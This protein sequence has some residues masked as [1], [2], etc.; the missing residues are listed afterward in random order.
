MD[1]VFSRDL[2]LNCC[3]SSAHPIIMFAAMKGCNLLERL[4]VCRCR[5][6]S[7][8]FNMPVA[9]SSWKVHWQ[10]RTSSWFKGTPSV[11]YHPLRGLISKAE[12]V[13]RRDY[14]LFV[15]VEHDKEENRN[16][17]LSES[18]SFFSEK[19]FSPVRSMYLSN[20]SAEWVLKFKREGQTEKGGQ[21]QGRGGDRLCEEKG[22]KRE[23]KE[24]GG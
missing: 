8:T 12:G 17:R 3:R 20:S 21:R 24:G 5:F 7:H 2:R 13:F 23:K 10:F 11:C 18:W 15:G 1:V 4:R 16:K 14:K 9:H 22:G 6:S 19:L